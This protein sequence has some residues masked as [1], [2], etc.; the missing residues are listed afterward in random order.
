MKQA[1]SY[2]CGIALAT[3]LIL[4]AS[5]RAQEKTP[6]TAGLESVL[7]RMDTAASN[8]RTTEAAFVWTQ[9]TKI[10]D[11]NDTQKGEVYFRRSGGD[12]QMAADIT[13]P[14]KKYVLFNGSRV[15]VYEPRIDQVTVYNPGKNREAVES[16]LV[17]GFGGRGHDLAKSFDVT[18]AG[19]EKLDGEETAKID[20]VPRSDRVRGMFTHITLWIDPQRGISVQQ[21]LWQP[22][23]DYRLA[24]YSDIHINQKI[25]EGV[26]KLKTTG[27]TKSA[28]PQG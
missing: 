17:L 13:A 1:G 26:F 27:K 10:V 22:N 18:Y 20:L 3:L 16:F 23:G 4:S 21:Q 9:Y 5:L 25:S 15:E 19:T 11:E 12:I 14:A 6:S 28:S 7:D 8:F 2:R 24:K